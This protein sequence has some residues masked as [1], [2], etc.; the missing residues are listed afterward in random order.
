MTVVWLFGIGLFFSWGRYVLF[1]AVYGLHT[2]QIP[3][4]YNHNFYF[5]LMVIIYL[6]LV[7]LTTFYNPQYKVVGNK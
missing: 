7:S 2:A 4:G 3:T 5:G 1:V 6:N